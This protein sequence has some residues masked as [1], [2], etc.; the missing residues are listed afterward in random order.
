M[1]KSIV[2]GVG[3]ALIA[4]GLASFLRRGEPPPAMPS[5][6]PGSDAGLAK[7]ESMTPAAMRTDSR[8]DTP[9]EERA[10]LV[11]DDA[12]LR[13]FRLHVTQ[14]GAA[15]P[16][17]TLRIA[18][19]H[20]PSGGRR[21]QG[22]FVTNQDGCVAI[23]AP[24]DPLRLQCSGETG[25]GQPFAIAVPV[26]ADALVVELRLPDPMVV[27]G[28]VIDERTG[29]GVADARVCHVG[30]ATVV[31]TDQTGGFVVTALERDL[32]TLEVTKAGYGIE[33]AQLWPARAS[34]DGPERASTVVALAPGIEL[35][36]RLVGQETRRRTVTLIPNGRIGVQPG[37]RLA[38]A[39][40]DAGRF[41]STEVAA[42][43]ATVVLVE[44]DGVP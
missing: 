8:H 31:H 1:K 2:L 44:V 13:T 27:S 43:M 11:A 33:F 28:R 24:P 18:S 39:V 30:S 37:T 34:A 16:G 42:S 36:G 20:L 3:I 21:E 26:A 6:D 35:R 9:P 38:V 14:G 29:A 32:C 40:D 5:R 12:S 19:Q 4:V 23:T 41:R 22:T 17:L 15:V 25:F 10:A 7:P